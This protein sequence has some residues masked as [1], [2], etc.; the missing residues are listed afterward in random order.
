MRPRPWT[1]GELLKVTSGYMKEKGIDSPR[2]TAEVLLAHLLHLN[3]VSLY[4]NFDQPLTQ[5]EISGY[6]SLVRRRLGREPLQYITGVQEFWS[7]EFT[8]DRRVLIPRPET[9]ILVEQAVKLV[10][11]G[12]GLSEESPRILDIGTGSG[13]IAVSLA[14]ELEGARIWATD[15]SAEALDIAG[16]NASKHGVVKRIVF[17][18]GDLW[19]PVVNEHIKFDLILSNPPYVSEESY[20]ELPPEVRDH[21]PRTALDGLAQG[22]YYIEK[23][24]A[25]GIDFLKPR[26]WLMIEMAPDQTEEA[27]SIIERAGGYC[28]AERIRDYS[29]QYRVV[30]AQ[31][32]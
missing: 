24:I 22:M 31:K 20:A 19:D 21:E 27:L 5:E 30:K 12:G 7:L 4:L 25:R 28:N 10:K 23:I 1:I 17:E 14:K 11:A 8:V 16:I 3:R 26:A 9:E 29:R 13:A 2:L 6:R 18:H 15:I 32:A